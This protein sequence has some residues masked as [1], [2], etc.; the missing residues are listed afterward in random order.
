M[1]LYQ[2]QIECVWVLTV[3]LWRHLLKRFRMTMNSLC[4]LQSVPYFT[5]MNRRR[6]GHQMSPLSDFRGP[7]VCRPGAVRCPTVH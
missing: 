1:A 4:T 2:R 6:Y 3:P 7:P 5:S